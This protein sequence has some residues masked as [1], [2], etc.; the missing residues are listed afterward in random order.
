MTSSYHSTRPP[1]VTYNNKIFSGKFMSN[2]I[3]DLIVSYVHFTF[4]SS[5]DFKSHKITY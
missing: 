4:I 1:R 2:N 3:A 5:D